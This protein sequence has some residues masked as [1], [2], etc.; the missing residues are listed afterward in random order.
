MHEEVYTNVGQFSN[1][2]LDFDLVFSLVFTMKTNWHIYI[3]ELE[4]E[5]IIGFQMNEN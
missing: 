4:W 1:A 3:W 2:H 5:P